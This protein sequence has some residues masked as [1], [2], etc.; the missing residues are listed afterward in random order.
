M[1]DISSPTNSRVKHIKKLLA[2]RRYRKRENEFVIE[3][4]RWI[5]EIVHS[6][7]KLS[8]WLATEQWLEENPQLA[9][10]LE[11][12]T[13]R[14][15]T[16]EPAILKSI[17]DTD[18]PSGVLAVTP[19]PSPAWPENP[20]FVLML[21]QIRDPGNLGTLIRSALAAGA[22]GIVLGNGCVDR[23]N[24]KVVRSSM[25]ALLRLPIQQTSWAGGEK[26]WGRCQVYLAD[27][28]GDTAYTKV[29][30]NRPSA[31]MIGGEANGAGAEARAVSDAL[32]SI[33]MAQAS[34]SLNAGVAGSIILFEA[35]R[36]R[37][38]S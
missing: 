8:I 3:G 4:T 36:Q 1:A 7:T 25:G 37:T 32:I 10:Q 16:I 17:A 31:I 21:D 28:A 24:P 13:G 2:D 19:M 6:Q 29:D 15:L 23:F 22:Q 26:L 14:P 30:W 18:N 5:D 11:Q 27:A 35:L 20:D 9:A 34:E 12:Q 33:P 38:E